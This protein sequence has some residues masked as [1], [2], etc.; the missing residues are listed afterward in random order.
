MVNKDPFYH[1]GNIFTLLFWLSSDI[2]VL[3]FD[4]S[5][6][7]QIVVSLLR[8]TLLHTCQYGWWVQG[9]NILNFCKILLSTYFPQ[10]T[11]SSEKVTE[12]EKIVIDPDMK[13]RFDPEKE[14]FFML[15]NWNKTYEKE[16][17][18]RASIN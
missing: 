3:S 9:Q 18:G 2:G 13:K 1:F 14:M 5:F 10:F 4:W 6:S 11:C 15:F 16:I 12:K 8:S 17:I 7:N